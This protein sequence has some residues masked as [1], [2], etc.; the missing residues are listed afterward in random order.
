[1]VEHPNIFGV[2]WSEFTRFVIHAYALK[3]RPAFAALTLVL[4]FLPGNNY[5]LDL[6]LRA[7]DP[8]VRPLAF[9]LPHASRYPVADPTIKPP[10]LTARSA[11]VIDV[12][13]ASIL[14]AKNPDERLLPASTT[15]IMTALVALNHYP[16]ENTITIKQADRAIGQ[17]MNLVPGE[18]ISVESL[19]YGLLLESGNDAA[20]ALA[21]NYPGGYTGFVGAMNRMAQRLHM[22]DTQFRNVSGIEQSGHYTTV[23][24]LARLAVIAIQQSIFSKIVSTRETVVTSADGKIVHRLLN[25]NELLGTVP[26][27]RGIKTGWTEHAGECLVTYTIR[28]GN[29]VIVAILGSEDRFKE[30]SLLIEW[31]YRAHTWMEPN[32]LDYWED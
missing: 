13:S 29:E 9:T 16:L 10:S 17:T 15:K 32:A 24:D 21:E 25:K 18:E 12:Q 2:L 4:I 30:S 1:M 23:R 6:T 3:K 7:K 19:L 8:P 26:G 14:Y 31:V 11:I 22:T 20:F 5:Y 28:D 27:T